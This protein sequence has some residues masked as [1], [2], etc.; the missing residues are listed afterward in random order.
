MS[1]LEKAR[2]ELRQ[3]AVDYAG[4]IGTDYDEDNYV[5]QIARLEVAAERFTDAKRDPI[6]PAVN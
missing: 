6:G 3:A 1:D 2:G 5:N 4:L